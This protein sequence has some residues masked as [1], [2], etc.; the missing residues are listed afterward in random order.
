MDPKCCTKRLFSAEELTTIFVV[1]F[2][3]RHYYI[4]L[5]A[6][7]ACR[8]YVSFFVNCY[9]YVSCEFDRVV[10]ASGALVPSSV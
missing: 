6:S 7:T 4:F 5:H 8:I 9:K 10:Y 3:F 1:L 2:V